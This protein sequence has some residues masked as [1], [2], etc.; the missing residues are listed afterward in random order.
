VGQYPTA[1]FITGILEVFYYNATQGALRQ[2]QR[3]G[4]T[5]SYSDVAGGSGSISGYTGNAG[6]FP[7]VTA[8][9]L[10]QFP[11][12]VDVFFYDVSRAA[13][14]WG[15]NS[16][17][18][19]IPWNFQQADGSPTSDTNHVGKFASSTLYNGSGGCDNGYGGPP[20]V[21]YYDETASALRLGIGSSCFVWGTTPLDGGSGSISGYAGNVGQYVATTQYG[22]LLVAF[23]YDAT[24]GALREASASGNLA[25]TFTQVDGGATGSVSGYTGNVGQGGIATTSYGSDLMVFY[26]DA[27]QS[28][29]RQATW[30]GSTWSFVQLDGG[31][32]AAL[33]AIM[34]FL[35]LR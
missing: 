18:A 22:S 15:E 11:T 28:A 16:V 2:A 8:R 19:H 26:Y 23:Y 35:L 17:G 30:N 31:D 27:S 10:N 13:L 25:F 24:K 6:Q 1:T 12:L 7:T 20:F 4:S 21:F 34:T 32:S 33:A 9:A 3:N 14:S 5:W 29:L